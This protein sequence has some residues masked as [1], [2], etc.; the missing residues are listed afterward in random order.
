MDQSYSVTDRLKKSQ[1]LRVEYNRWMGV[2][3]VQCEEVPSWMFI[4]WIS[5]MTALLDKPE[6][7]AVHGILLKLADQYPEVCTP[8]YT[9]SS[10]ELCRSVKKKALA[11][12]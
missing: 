1:C 11:G 4:A 3:W 5:Q 9:I 12:V 10:T 7:P 6:S 2:V 8:R